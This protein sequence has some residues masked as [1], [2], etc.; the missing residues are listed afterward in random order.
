VIALKTTM[1]E[2]RLREAGADW[3][4]NNCSAVTRDS[5]PETAGQVRLSLED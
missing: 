2:L 1:G 3:V 5:T 4:V